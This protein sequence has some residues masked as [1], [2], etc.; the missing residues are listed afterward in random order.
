MKKVFRKLKNGSLKKQLIIGIITIIITVLMVLSI[1]NYYIAYKGILKVSSSYNQQ[2]VE[3]LCKNVDIYCD[4]IVRKIDSLGNDP[5]IKYYGNYFN[6][7]PSNT[8]NEVIKDTLFQSVI[9]RVDI[10]DINILYNQQNIVS[11]FGLYDYDTLIEIADYY[12]AKDIYLTAKIVPIITT[13]KY[14]GHSISL[15]KS[16]YAPD[17]INNRSYFIVAHI[18]IKNIETIL[19]DIDLGDGSGA[20]L[21]DIKGEQSN[22]FNKFNQV[23]QNIIQE[24]K[25]YKN[26]AARSEIRTILGKDYLISNNPLS[27]A[28]LNIIVYNPVSNLTQASK[29]IKNVSIILITIGI[30]I[31]LALTMLITNLFTKPIT[32]LVNHMSHISSGNLKPISTKNNTIEAKILYE[33]FNEMMLRIEQ[34]MLDIDEKNK[35]KRK[36]ELY[37]LQAQ[38]NPHFLYNTLDSIN[39][40]AILNG[41]KDI[42]HM[43]V[44]L[45]RLLRLSI[46]TEYEFVKISDEIKHAKYY[47]EIQKIRYADRFEVKFEVENNVLEYEVLKLILQPLIENALYH[48]IELKPGKGIIT[49]KAYEEEDAIVIEVLDNGLGISKD[50]VLEVT[51]KLKENRL[52]GKSE[53][54]GLYNVNSRIKLHYGQKY[55]L[56]LE[57]E[58]GIGTKVKIMIPKSKSC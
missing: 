4:E 17:E 1:T 20:F 34:L 2:L 12:Q 40:M 50:E 15:I 24:A 7:V 16:V 51:Q 28:G 14:G 54:V 25:Q 49:I 19:K 6:T 39:A 22:I 36:A 57:S 47:L 13:N 11:M 32:Q 58:K 31:T 43:T 26:T 23:E 5:N 3:Q 35:L 53:S 46:S 41:S 55:S 21:V 42:M 37:A 38:I 8:S 27:Y 18:D 30:F 29:S 52:F 9:D 56:K 10:D 48:G 45:A 33:N 44:A